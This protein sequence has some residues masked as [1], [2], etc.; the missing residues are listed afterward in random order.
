MNRHYLRQS[1]D[2]IIEVLLSI[3]ILGLVLAGAYSLA[4]RNLSS[5]TQAERRN[6]ALAAAQGQVERIIN[7]QNNDPAKLI[8]YT[9]ASGDFCIRD[10]NTRVAADSEECV[11]YGDQQ[12]ALSVQYDTSTKVFTVT[13]NWE[14]DSRAQ[15]DQLTLYYKLPGT[16]TGALPSPSPSPPPG[17]PGPPPNPLVIQWLSDRAGGDGSYFAWQGNGTRTNDMIYRINL[18]TPIPAGSSYSLIV[19]TFDSTH[20]WYTVSQEQEQIYI[21]FCN[22]S[23]GCN[24][25]FDRRDPNPS[26]N[27]VY[28]TGLTTDIPTSDLS[29]ST[30][31]GQVIFSRQVDY[32]LI[33]HVCDYIVESVAEDCRDNRPERP[34]NQY[35][36]VH[37]TDLTLT[38]I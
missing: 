24:Q 11:A 4:N 31:M 27:P 16:Y 15:S 12:Y 7:A 30:N 38:L 35:N 22:D 21:E 8:D 6:Q 13:A 28:R 26:P 36:S 17:P 3:T 25:D 37:G 33:K 14:A 20:S 19:D 34:N 23:G 32:I 9:T 18:T 5:G 29:V 1:G 2:T 10:D